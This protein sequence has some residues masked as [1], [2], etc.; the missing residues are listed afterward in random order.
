MKKTIKQIFLSL[1]VAQ[2]IPCMAFAGGQNPINNLVSSW[3]NPTMS[4]CNTSKIGNATIGKYKNIC[5]GNYKIDANSPRQCVLIDDMGVLMM[6][7]RE[8]NENGAKFCITTVYAE[9]E[10]KGKAWTLYGEPAE[11]AQPCYWLCKA[12]FHGEK[13]Q[14]TTPTGCDSTPFLR[15]N[16]DKFNMAREPKV[17]SAIAMFHWNEYKG[18]GAHSSQEHD[19]LLVISDWLE[20]GHGAWATP[21]VVRARRE[22]WKS[23]RGGIDAWPAGEPT[24]LCKNGYTATASGKDCQAVDEKTCAMTQ[25]CSNWPDN[26]FDETTMDLFW[27]AEKQCYQ[28]RC[29]EYGYAFPSAD[30]KTCQSCFSNYRGGVS[31][32]DGTCVECPLG[33]VFDESATGYCRET[34]SYLQSDLQYGLNKNQNTAGINKV[35]CWMKT[36]IEEYKACVTGVAPTSSDKNGKNFTINGQILKN[37]KIQL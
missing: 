30:N 32:V 29:K 16:F 24:L 2:F 8:V 31:P 14:D 20:N 36:D 7:A 19:M 27:N 10:R 15:E 3:K 18:C 21:Y 1:L 22:G 28:Y 26:K 17:E 33:Q 5:V 11:G 6:V 9:H 12:G 34:K 37:L 35:A 25:L 4:H 13:C 23:K